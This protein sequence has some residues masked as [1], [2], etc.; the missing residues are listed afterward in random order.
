MKEMETTI[1]G[2]GQGACN[3]I[4]VFDYELCDPVNKKLVCL[5]IVDCGSLTNGTLKDETLTFIKMCMKKR[6]IEKKDLEYKL[7]YYLDFLIVTHQDK[8]HISWLESLFKDVSFPPSLRRMYKDSY[9][10]MEY[11]SS[12]LTRWC[13]VAYSGSPGTERLYSGTCKEEIVYRSSGFIRMGEVLL[14]SKIVLKNNDMVEKS[15]KFKGNLSKKLIYSF[16]D[17]N[18][19]Y[20][21][22]IRI[23]DGNPTGKCFVYSAD[24]SVHISK[25]QGGEQC[26]TLTILCDKKSYEET[27][28]IIETEIREIV[29]STLSKVKR[30]LK[31]T[32]IE[33]EKQQSMCNFLDAL[34]D[35]VNE[36]MDSNS[37]ILVFQTPKDVEAYIDKKIGL[38]GIIDYLVYGGEYDPDNWSEAERSDK[39][40]SSDLRQRV[41]YT[42]SPLALNETRPYGIQEVSQ[43]GFAGVTVKMFPYT[44]E[45]LKSLTNRANST[46]VMSSVVLQPYDSSVFFPG[47]ATWENMVNFLNSKEKEGFKFPEL[48]TAPHHGAASTAIYE[49]SL[50]TMKSFLKYL[51]PIR[52]IVSA[53]FD[54]SYN[55]PYSSV[56]EYYDQLVLKSPVRTKKH[57]CYYYEADKISCKDVFAYCVVDSDLYTTVTAI[58]TN[59]DTPPKSTGSKYVDYC[60]IIPDLAPVSEDFQIIFET[61]DVLTRAENS[62]I[63]K[64]KV[65]ICLEFNECL[66]PKLKQDIQEKRIVGLKQRN[67]SPPFIHER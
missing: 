54:N 39:K 29:T 55:H 17:K 6:A 26:Y 2:V 48:M 15:C 31:K 36:Q 59:P 56:M 53:G 4:Q 3:V 49:G 41:Y 63:N 24:I 32:E 66:R 51:Y 35:A 22:K 50:N 37:P 52:I 67:F 12:D 33:A 45:Y 46:S 27:D 14:T 5:G 62:L 7:D 11:I 9:T 34:E 61:K 43:L 18:D 57:Y 30:F 47:D 38:T 23:V 8:D 1:L 44:D 64:N 65:S 25:N 40:K 16:L 13:S 10:K 19:A 42:I 28:Y 58:D 60:L 20:N 21:L